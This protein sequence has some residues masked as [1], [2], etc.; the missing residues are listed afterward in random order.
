MIVINGRIVAQA[1]QFDVH[2]VHV[3]TA[4]VDLDD[5]RSYRASNPAF[6]IQAARMVTDEGGGGN[7]G[8]M[9][10][11]VHLV[12]DPM[13]TSSFNKNRP[14]ITDESMTLKIAAPEEEC[15][16]GPACWMWD[17]LRRSGAAGFFLPLSGKYFFC[18]RFLVLRRL[19]YCCSDE[20]NSKIKVDRD[21]RINIE[22]Y[23]SL[24]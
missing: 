17:F 1:P 7:Y 23:S 11:D 6:G 8:L 4:T 12:Y 20:M 3:I 15:C 22:R 5:V 21:I 16:L 24:F 18:Y 2:D 9:Y 14:K 13:D 19:I 10:D